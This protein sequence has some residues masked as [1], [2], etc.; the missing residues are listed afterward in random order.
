[1]GQS[2]RRMV[3]VLLITAAF[4][5]GAPDLA[6]SQDYPTK[7]INMLI[8]FRPGGP[9]DIYPRLI[10]KKAEP[11]LGQ[12][13]VCSND[14]GGGGSVALAIVAKQKPDGYHLAAPTSAHL[15]RIPQFRTVPYKHEDFIPLLHYGAPGSGIVVKGDSPWKTLKEFLDYAKKN[16]GKVSYTSLG[17]GSPMHIA[18]E[19]IAKQ[20]GITWTHIPADPK[21]DPIVPVL[22]GHVTASSAGVTWIPH[23][24][25][26]ELRLLA[27]LGEKRMKKFPDAPTL[28]ELGYDFVNEVVY[29]LAAPKGTPPVIVK[30]L[31]EAFQKSLDADFVQQLE[32]FDVEFSY[33]NSEETRRYL[34]EAYVRL[35]K[36]IHELKIPKEEEKK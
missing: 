31:E 7:P 14:G 25:A 17:I 35:G 33:R 18:M 23:V 3:G 15:I 4:A 10:A 11:F 24:K 6:L 22:G 21:I 28:C 26:G 34:D 5:A 32:K 36:L 20:E 19:Y 30:K 9:G 16:P 29:I 1:M 2:K 12:P 8:G 27:T 13:F